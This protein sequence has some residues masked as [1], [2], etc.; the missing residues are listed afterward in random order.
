M[1]G[2]RNVPMKWV[3]WLTSIVIGVSILS[4]I[5]MMFWI[6]EPSVFQY[7]VSIALVCFTLSSIA[8]LLFSARVEISG[9]AGLLSWTLGGTAALWVASLLVVSSIFPESPILAPSY[10]QR[11]NLLFPQDAAANPFN[12]K[13]IGYLQRHGQTAATVYPSMGVDRG[14]G[15]LVVN[16]DDLHLGDK[17]YVITMDGKKKWRSDD[18]VTPTAH[19][20]MNLL[21]VNQP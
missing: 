8:G 17:L 2:R 13:V 7:R 4:V 5:V 14:A 3:V 20:Q 12:A 1:D 19:L 10:Q 15:G 21:T 11:L 16:F 6:P 9:K 18:M